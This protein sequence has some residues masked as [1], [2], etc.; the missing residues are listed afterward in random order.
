MYDHQLYQAEYR[1]THRRES[2]AYRELHRED[3]RIYDEQYRKKYG[4]LSGA[5]KRK[6][7]KIKLQNG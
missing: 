1:R 4:Q 7:A 6:L 2:Q 3:K 5:Q